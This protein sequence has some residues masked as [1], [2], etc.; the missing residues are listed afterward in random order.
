M[1]DGVEL[2]FTELF[3][4]VNQMLQVFMEGRRHPRANCGDIRVDK[5]H[6]KPGKAFVFKVTFM[7]GFQRDMSVEFNAAICAKHPK[8]YMESWI[9]HI[10]EA[11][12][13]AT[14]QLDA[15]SIFLPSDVPGLLQKNALAAAI[16][17]SGVVH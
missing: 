13:E 17:Q 8:R 4:T 14:R 15:P 16:N 11:Y 9:D 10:N 12:L 7:I 1:S 2:N 5:L 3:E 6:G